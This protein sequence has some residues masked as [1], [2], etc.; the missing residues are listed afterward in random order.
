[1]E[2]SVWKQCILAINVYLDIYVI[3]FLQNNY[4]KVSMETMYISYQEILIGSTTSNV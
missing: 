4:G 2:K 1:M 3:H